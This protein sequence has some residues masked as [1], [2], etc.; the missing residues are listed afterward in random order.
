MHRLAATATLAL[1]VTACS[2]GAP[3][4]TVPGVSLPPGATANVP[5][6]PPVGTPGNPLPNG[7][8]PEARVRALIPPGA[9]ELQAAA[10]GGSYSVTLS[11]PGPLDQLEAFWDQAAPAAGVTVTGKVANAGT[12]TYGFTDPD[13][14]IVAVPNGSGGYVITISV[15][16][17]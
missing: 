14:G 2:S 17:T 11:H 8:T 10:V 3:G 4:P 16:I 13:G 6:L 5:T 12:L 1:I 7:G 15:G 9:T